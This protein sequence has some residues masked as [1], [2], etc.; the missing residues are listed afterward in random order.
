MNPIR[1]MTVKKL[2]PTFKSSNKKMESLSKTIQ[3]L[4]DQEYTDLLNAVGGRKQNK[5][6]Q[7]LEASRHHNYNESQVLPAF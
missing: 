6:Y 2:K 3:K 7:L 4:N 5:P 1:K